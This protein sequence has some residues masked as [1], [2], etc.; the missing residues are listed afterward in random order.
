MPI[1]VENLKASVAKYA[2]QEMILGA[3]EEDMRFG[4]DPG[5]KGLNLLIGSLIGQK[6]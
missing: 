5:K 4:P 2:L 6:R 3:R 1:S